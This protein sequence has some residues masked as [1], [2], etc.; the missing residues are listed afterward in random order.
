MSGTNAKQEIAGNGVTGDLSGSQLNLH[1][2][3]ENPN[4]YQKD[5]GN[6]TFA[7]LRKYY[8]VR[9]KGME[10]FVQ[11]CAYTKDKVK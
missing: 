4:S 3:L 1:V 11:F 2:D 6:T 5:N 9:Y 7:S 8:T 10:V